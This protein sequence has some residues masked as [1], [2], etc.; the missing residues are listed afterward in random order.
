MP[1]NAQIAAAF[2]VFDKNGDGA[3]AAEELAA[4][5][6]RQGGGKPLSKEQAQ[7]I[8]DKHDKDGDGK[9]QLDELAGGA[10]AEICKL[11]PIT[12]AASEITWTKSHPEVYKVE[13]KCDKEIKEILAEAQE[14][15]AAVAA[16][17]KPLIEEAKAKYGSGT[18]VVP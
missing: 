11:S 1:N 5:L 4:I 6:T 7:A 17:Y 14:K 13:Q 15:A 2:K 16:K 8:I 18:E 10:W 3:L 9:L 12:T